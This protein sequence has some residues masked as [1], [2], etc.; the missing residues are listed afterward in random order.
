MP[1]TWSQFVARV[2][3]H[4][5]V[6]ANRVGAEDFV[7]ASIRIAV[8][9]IQDA[10]EYYRSGHE[11]TFEFDDATQDGFASTF[12]LPENAYIRQALHVQQTE[13]CVERPLYWYP[14]TNRRD[15]VCGVVNITHRFRFTVDPRGQKLTVYPALTAGYAVKLAWDGVKDSFADA[16]VVPFDE[17]CAMVVANFVKARIAMDVE[18]DANRHRFYIAEHVLGVRDLRRKAIARMS[19]TVAVPSQADCVPGCECVASTACVPCGTGSGSAAP[20]NPITLP[21]VEWAMFGDSGDVST[22]PDTEVVASSV[23]SWNPPLIVHLGDT[24]YP[25]GSSVTLSDRF[26]RHYWSW[27]NSGDLFVAYGNHDLMTDYGHPISALLPAQRAAIGDANVEAR[28]LWFK[29]QRGPVEF[30][31]LNSGLGPSDADAK[32]TQQYSWLRGALVASSAIWKIVVLHRAPYSSDATHGPGATE[33]RW[34]FRAWG[35]DLVVAAHGHHY[36]RLL[37]DGLPYLVCGL[38]GAPRYPAGT[39]LPESQ[40]RWS[41]DV[42]FL[43]CS[44]TE[45]TLQITLVHGKTGADIDRLTLIDTGTGESFVGGENYQIVSDLLQIFNLTASNYSTIRLVGASS[46]PSLVFD[47]AGVTSPPVN[48][49]WVTPTCL[50]L[51][52]S[53]ASTWH[54]LYLFGN[55]S[56]PSFAVGAANEVFDSAKYEDSLLKLKNTT[57]GNYHP[58]YLY[59]TPPSIVVA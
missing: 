44:A 18:R 11:T 31:V 34:P 16:D 57:S 30:F 5:T 45:R 25:N 39:L 43:R 33:F 28:K 8:T 46:A 22:L 38:G 9:K 48:F 21:T 14:W 40:F 27:I 4:L 26:A 49:R 20:A 17:E 58:I 6:D 36:E 7:A 55:A 3:V 15:L 37:V 23:R 47:E 51:W 12:A 2:N 13:R 19:E 56:A 29:V 50:Q 41:S 53:T 54:P 42:G 24:N 35:A 1:L 52:N 32:R 59:G 10:I